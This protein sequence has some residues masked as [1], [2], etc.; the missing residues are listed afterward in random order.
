MKEK[1]SAII[2]YVLRTHG[3][4]TS[5]YE[6]TFLNKSIQNRMSKTHCS[7]VEE[8]HALMVDN[9]NEVDRFIDSLQI[10]YTDF[11][12]NTLTFSVLEK[13]I[14]PSLVVKT[15][16]SNR[17]EIRIWSSACA[18]GQETYSLAMILNE[19]SNGK[20]GKINYRIFATDQSEMQLLEAELGEYTES[21]VNSLSLK[22]VNRWFTKQGEKYVVKPELKEHIEFSVFDLLNEKFSC[23]P[24]SIYGDFDL[25][26]CANLLFYYQPEYRKKMIEKGRNCMARNGYLITGETEREL[27]IQAGFREAYPMSAI[28]QV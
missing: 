22:R 7:S 27:L 15:M 6:P 11:F 16:N 9:M 1:Y 13:V 24:T 12:R 5:K 8:Y 4:D 25:V 17:N 20:G 28:F 18:S 19:F 26:F 2:D 21:E 23:P 10:C 3:V 14:L